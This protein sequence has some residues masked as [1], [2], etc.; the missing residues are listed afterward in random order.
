MIRFKV[1][2]IFL[3][4]TFYFNGF[5]QSTDLYYLCQSGKKAGNGYSSNSSLPVGYDISHITINVDTISFANFTI[6][7]MAEI[8]LHSQQSGLTVFELS[9]LQL[10]IDSILIGNQNLTYGYNDTTL[11]ITLNPVLN[12]GDSA[13]VK[14]FYNGTPKVDGSGWGGFYFSGSYAFNVK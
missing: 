5:T 4:S 1:L 9:L 10:N 3:L 14:V 11:S 6:R 7:A 12:N 8:T 13:I 2:L